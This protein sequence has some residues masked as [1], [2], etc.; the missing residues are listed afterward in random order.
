MRVGEDDIGCHAFLVGFKPSCGTQAP[1]ISFPKPFKA[2]LRMRCREVISRKT[3]VLKKFGRDFNTHGMRTHVFLAGI[4]AGISKK[5]GQGRRTAGHQGAAQDVDRGVFLRCL[6][7][8][9]AVYEAKDRVSLL[10]QMGSMCVVF[11]NGL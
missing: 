7:L 4:A 5:P 2:K 8:V 6:H 1:A 9:V 11:S 3:R 10:L